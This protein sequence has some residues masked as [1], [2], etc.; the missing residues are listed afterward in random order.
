VTLV[1][2]L[3]AG[4]AFADGGSELRASDEIAMLRDAQVAR[5]G[6]RRF[7]TSTG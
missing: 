2:V 4:F 6:D 5:L 7:A 1:E 3:R